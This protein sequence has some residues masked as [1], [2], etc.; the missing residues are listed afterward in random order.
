MHSKGVEIGP[1]DP[2]GSHAQALAYAVSPLGPRYDAVE[3]DIDFDPEWGVPSFIER[4][5]HHGCPPGG[6]PM[7]CLDNRK[8][9]LLANLWELWS[10]Y[11]VLGLCTF[12]SPP[13]RVL[14]EN[15]VLELASAATGWE[16]THEEVAAWGRRRL[17]TMRAYNLREGLTRDQD[18]LPERFFTRPV[19]AG[20]LRGVTLDRRAFLRGR[21][22]LWARWDEDVRPA[23]PPE[24]RV[25]AL[26]G[27]GRNGP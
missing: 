5:R 17:Q 10:G 8:L 24:R 15:D 11:D 3:H 23:A 7:A 18:D 21:A 1:W 14:D 27:A 9:E 26:S 2:R 4:A 20:R 19:D 6:L 16:V 12:V 22:W 25:N 13:T